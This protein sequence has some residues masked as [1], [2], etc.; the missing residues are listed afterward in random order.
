MK[1]SLNIFILM[2]FMVTSLFQGRLCA[3]ETTTA[4]D[5]ILKIE[6]AYKGIVDI[7]GIF[8]QESRIEDLERTDTYK[9]DFIIKIPSKVR[10][11][12]KGK[13]YQEIYINGPEMIIFQKKE[14]QA[15]KSRFDRD[16]YGQAPVA[17]LGGF[18]NIRKEF[19]ITKK[20]NRLE[21]RP[22]VSMGAVSS[23]EIVPSEGE[24]PIK[25]IIVTDRHSNTVKVT[26]DDIKL[27]TGIK[28]SEFIFP[29]PKGVSVY[30][31]NP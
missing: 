21:L 11:R 19:D 18:G 15:F 26:L 6:E 8:V 12:Y 22:K 23:I 24:F 29:A 4:E 2:A 17:L 16:G 28:D 31:H 14:N 20:G 1:T 10:W 13:D 25:S 30:E 9:G 3:A 5:D 27:N 7:K